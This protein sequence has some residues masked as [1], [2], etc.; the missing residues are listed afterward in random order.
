MIFTH[1]ILE[2][3]AVFRVRAMTV[4]QMS[5]RFVLMIW[6]IFL[7]NSVFG[8]DDLFRFDSRLFPPDDTP[9]ETF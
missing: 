3:A 2:L 4:K 9:D 1:F 5:Q 7:S 6:T 8:E